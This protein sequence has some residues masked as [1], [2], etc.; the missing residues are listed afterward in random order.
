[1]NECLNRVILRNFISFAQ[2]RAEKKMNKRL[3]LLQKI[4]DLRKEC[5]E[6]EDLNKRLKARKFSFIQRRAKSKKN[7]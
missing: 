7:N 1:M 4:L 3:D 6:K 5:V 2:G